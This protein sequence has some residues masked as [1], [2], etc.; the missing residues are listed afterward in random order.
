MKRP[1][2][3]C[4]WIASVTLLALVSF[5]AGTSLACFQKGTGTIAMA[6]DCCKGH[7]QHVM[8]GDMAAKCCQSHQTKVSQAL[9]T[10]PS[11]K[12]IVLGASAVHSFLIPPVVLQGPKQ[13]WLHLSTGERSPPSPPFYTV[14]CT[15]LL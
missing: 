6:E 3:H 13:F 11:A 7:C 1:Q 2:K 14:H 9:A 8:V 15:L 10:T 12:A 4:L 5:L